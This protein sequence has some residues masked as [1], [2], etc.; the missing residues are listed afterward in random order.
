MVVDLV[1][2]TFI[3]SLC[4]NLEMDWFLRHAVYFLS[5][6]HSCESCCSTHLMEQW[7]NEQSELTGC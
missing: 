4:V 5:C 7:S 2:M 3:A 6:C 1:R